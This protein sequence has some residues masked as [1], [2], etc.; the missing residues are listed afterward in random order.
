MKL[1]FR[2]NLKFLSYVLAPVSA[3]LL[4]SAATVHADCYDRRAPGIDWSGCKKNQQN[5]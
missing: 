4:L 3:I 2:M 5:A 1:M